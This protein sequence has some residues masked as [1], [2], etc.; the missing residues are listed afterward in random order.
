VARVLYFKLAAEPA[1]IS[2]STWKRLIAV[3]AIRKV[4]VSEERVGV[5][6]SDFDDACISR[7]E[8]GII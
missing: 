8:T 4:R 5:L 6:V 2:L 3:G 7:V 1:D